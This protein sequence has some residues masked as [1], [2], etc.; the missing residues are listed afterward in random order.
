MEPHLCVRT[1][2]HKP[3]WQP[4]SEEA[5]GFDMV[6]KPLEIVSCDYPLSS[7]PVEPIQMGGRVLRLV[8]S[9]G[10]AGGRESSKE[11]IT[12]ALGEETGRKEGKEGRRNA[13]HSN[14]SVY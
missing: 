8:L 3:T 4:Y 2:K 14:N 10:E 9:R 1:L 12:R 11:F 7:D 13:N 5:A 6:P